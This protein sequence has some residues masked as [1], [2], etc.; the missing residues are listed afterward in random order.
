MEAVRAPI[1]R[2]RPGPGVPTQQEVVDNHGAGG[3]GVGDS[4]KWGTARRHG[5]PESV[6]PSYA[7]T[8]VMDSH[9][10]PAPAQAYV[11]AVVPMAQDERAQKVVQDLMQRYG[12][13]N[14]VV[15]SVEKSAVLRRGGEGRMALDVDEGMAMLDRAEETVVL[16][17]VQAMAARNT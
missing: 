2:H 14:H 1:R 7:P 11:D 3:Y 4:A 9:G 16:G 5:G 13:D 17:K 6:P 8:D 15:W 10:I 12:R